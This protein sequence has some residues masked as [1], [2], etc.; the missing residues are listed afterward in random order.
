MRL[1]K[2]RGKLCSLYSLSPPEPAHQLEERMVC[3]E[4]GLRVTEKIEF[5][6]EENSDCE[7]QSP[8]VYDWHG[9]VNLEF[10]K[11]SRVKVSSTHCLG[12]QKN[13]PGLSNHLT[14]RI[15]E[16]KKI[17]CPQIVIHIEGIK[18]VLTLVSVLK[19]Y[20][21]WLEKG[22][23]F[24][25]MSKMTCECVGGITRWKKVPFTEIE[26]PGRWLVIG[27]WWQ[28]GK[29][30]GSVNFDGVPKYPKVSAK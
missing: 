14:P 2:Q 11:Y 16:D 27:L 13:Y 28:V 3:T 25:R 10:E 26:N 6:S 29:I 17:K 18:M 15:W 12:P 24:R 23:K 7:D 5:C 21:Q 9:F 22:M 4:F 1:L 19:R 20:Y 30:I 8:H